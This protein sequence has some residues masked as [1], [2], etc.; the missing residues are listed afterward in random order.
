MI[1]HPIRWPES[2]RKIIMHI[3]GHME[4]LN[5]SY[6]DVGNAKCVATL[7]NI[8]VVPQMV[9]HRAII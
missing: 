5:S 7:E 1:T 8:S 3:G 6:T 9:K 4:K 2:V